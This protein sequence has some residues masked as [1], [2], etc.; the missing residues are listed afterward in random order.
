MAYWN[1]SIT[2]VNYGT[3]ENDGTGDSI[4]QAF[5]YV[6]Q[7]FQNLN[8][9][10]SATQI[11][12]P[13]VTANNS[14][15][16]NTASNVFVGNI[17]R[18]DGATLGNL[19]VTGPTALNT[20]SVSGN[21]N[22]YGYTIVH[23]H[24]IPSANLL[25]NLGSPNAYFANIYTQ[26]L[27]QVNT[28]SA[29]SDAGLL[30]LHANLL[31]GDNKD[32]GVFGKFSTG[33]TSNAY[34][35][36]GV[37]DA[38]SNFV[39]KV[40]NTNAPAGNSVVYDGVYGNAQLGSLF[41]SNSTV[42]SSTN[43][44]AL[45]VAGGIGVMG[46]LTGNV[47][48]PVA[49]IARMTVSGTVAGNLT[50]DGNLFS[51]TY[52]VLTT[53][54]PGIGNIFNGTNSLFTGITNFAAAV[55]STG[56]STGAVTIQGGLGVGGNLNAAALFGPLTGLVLTPNQPNITA[57][58]TINSLVAL[59]GQ[60]NSLGVTSLTATGG[61]VSFQTFNASGNV[62][63]ANVAATQ[64]NGS[65]AGQVVTPT[66]TNITTLGT[67][68]NLAVAGTIVGNI[69]SPISN[70]TNLTA[71]A[72]YSN[73]Y[74]FANGV[75]YTT[76]TL[77]NTADITANIPSGF[78]SGLSLTPTGVNAGQYGN[79]TTAVTVT[80][81]TKGRILTATNVAIAPITLVGTNSTT[82][83]MTVGQT[84]N[85]SSNTGMVIGVGLNSIAINTPQ[86]LQPASTVSFGNVLVAGNVTSGFINS[87]SNIS[88][89]QGYINTVTANTVNAA[90]IGNTGST[91]TGTLQT[92]S[93]PNITAV[94]TLSALTVSGATNLAATTITGNLAITGPGTYVT[95]NMYIAGQLFVAGN[96]TT[97]NS[98]SITT[99]DLQIFL[100]AN[101][102]NTGAANGAGI[103]I[104]YGTFTYGA[105]NNGWNSNISI[106]AP[107][108]YDNS[109]RV[110]STSGGSGSLTLVDGN[111]SL[112]PVGNGPTTVGNITSIPVIAVDQYGRVT[113]L[114]RQQLPLLTTNAS[115][116][117]T[118]L[119][120]NVAATGNPGD[121][122]A[123]SLGV[124]TAP[125]GTAGEIRAT[126]NIT[127]YYSDD[128]LKTRL[129]KIENALD[130]VCSLEGFYY[131]A[132]ETAQ[133][134]GYDVKREV[135]LSAQSTQR[136]MAEIVA[137]AP[138]D[139]Q[140]LTIR[141]ERYAPYFVEAFKELREELRDIKRHLGLE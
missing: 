134:L 70:I 40:T 35:F 118:S 87:T 106:Y 77:A 126:N 30:Q 85:F 72:L 74:N 55:P 21:A 62:S 82:V 52:Q 141:Y 6:D 4:R 86:P 15:F 76:T 45:I 18:I 33:P 131:E 136:E 42:S 23:N 56:I 7:N 75:P 28:I 112:T 121:L 60:I 99:N 54:T 34:G 41:L 128:R 140:Y 38:T 113:S 57:L 5:I 20:L 25:Y 67:L 31:P 132:N 133:A 124:G 13:A 32:V 83:P 2:S 58:G 93:Q 51:G 107:K 73:S 14:S 89:P 122:Q 102:P 139:D 11:G 137:P 94:G 50:V 64:F 100:A 98:T 29:Q 26:G 44:G 84:M 69:S 117:F 48:A 63:A 116:Q 103:L 80:T 114:T 22:N 101:A 47:S 109:N 120:V 95:N 90:T 16:G 12:F 3:T 104:P 59:T 49:N 27:V 81:D 123:G 110:I 8:S 127:A 46:T 65:L 78:N 125:S 130:K 119:G 66:Q 88:T 43:T 9:Y 17:A 36:F 129:G 135:G 39:Y 105:M 79:A 53:G 1:S 10:L 24:V 61:T 91:L 68:T 71:T 92:A 37:Q 138:I 96:T 111:I 108:L 97:V 19:T 115:P